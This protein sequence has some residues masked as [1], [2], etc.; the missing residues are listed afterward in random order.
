MQDGAPRARA[1]GGVRVVGARGRRRR[2]QRGRRHRQPPRQPRRAFPRQRL[3]RQVRQDL[4][5]EHGAVPGD[6]G[7]ARQLGARRGVAPGRPL[8]AHGVRRQDAARVGRGAHALPQDS[9]RAPA[10]RH[11]SRFPQELA[12][13]DIRQ[14]R[15]D[16][17]SLGVSLRALP[18]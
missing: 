2:R 12:I 9:L 16:R 3:A 13:R 11:Q 4:G 17:Q 5:R 8:P 1:R 14:R 6:A 10:L 7:G 15:S 18:F